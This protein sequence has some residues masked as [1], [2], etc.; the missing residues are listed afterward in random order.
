M[1][2]KL[3]TLFLLGFIILFI[4]MMVQTLGGDK[5]QGGTAIA[6]LWLLIL[7]IPLIYLSF[8][9]G[10][11]D[12]RKVRGLLL[13]SRLYVFATLFVIFIQPL[14]LSERGISF[15]STLKISAIFLVPLAGFIGFVLWK[16]VLQKQS[17]V[18][19][20]TFPSEDAVVFISYNHE[21]KLVAF[22]IQDALEAAGIEVVIDTEDMFAGEDIKSFIEDC[23]R[24]T[25]VTLS[26]ISNRSLRSAWVAMETIHSFFLERYVENKK[27]IA[28]YIDEDFFQSDFT[29]NTIADIDKKIQQNQHLIL[30][31]HKK[32]LDTRN[33]NNENSRLLS[34]RNNLDEIVRRLRESLSLDVREPAFRISMQQLIKTLKED[35]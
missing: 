16:K 2:K 20:A 32:M 34:L 35:A 22:K 10:S 13:L 17:K 24:E 21:D 1:K 28:C 11:N 31:Q 30:K 33:L 4:M 14:A 19:D 18:S 29:L 26:L 23:V 8:Q 9:I 5:Y 7:Y 6:W 15:L 12:R 27:F 3:I 25:T